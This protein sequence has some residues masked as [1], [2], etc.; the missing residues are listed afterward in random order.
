MKN[1]R[2]I[3]GKKRNEEKKRRKKKRK[4]QSADLSF[5]KLRGCR[6]NDLNL[7]PPSG[8]E[9]KRKE[10]K[11]KEVIYQTTKKEKSTFHMLCFKKASSSTPLTLSWQS[12]ELAKQK[13]RSSTGRVAFQWR[14][15]VSGTQHVPSE[16][17]PFLFLGSASPKPGDL[18]VKLCRVM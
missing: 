17:D 12:S 6:N 7:V 8:K 18:G 9:K 1:K 15:G 14:F 3:G 4:A 16:E 13:F 11:K 2:R 5:P 10:G